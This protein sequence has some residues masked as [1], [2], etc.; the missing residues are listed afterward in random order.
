MSTKGPWATVVGIVG[1]LKGNARSFSETEI[2]QPLSPGSDADANLV[3]AAAADPSALIPV[4]KGQVWSLDPK[5]PIAHVTT[6]DAAMAETMSRPRFNLV[7]LGT[8]A[9]IGLLLAA[10]GIY[11]VI[12]VSVTQ[13]TQEIGLR[14]ALGALPRD[15]RR[16]VVGEALALAGIGLVVGVS[17]AMALTTAMRAMVYETSVHD[18]ASVVATVAMV[19]A[20]ALLA[21]WVPASRAMGVDPLEALRAD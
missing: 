12:S 16:S 11:G 2:Y 3:V 13:R 10:V 8:F 19:G 5:L 21:A 1:D 18:P 17:G 20:T 4:L 7:L 6:L 15:I 14:M 9:A